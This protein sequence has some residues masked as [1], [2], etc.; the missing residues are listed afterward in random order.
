ML[1]INKVV[2]WKTSFMNS[3]PVSL[4]RVPD[5]GSWWQPQ[6]LLKVTSRLCAGR[7]LLCPQPLMR[8]TFSLGLHG[9][10]EEANRSSG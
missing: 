7:Q 3:F 8:A 1:K 5:L 6:L 4:R 10:I 2:L 9:V